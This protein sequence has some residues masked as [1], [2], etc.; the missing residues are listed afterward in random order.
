VRVTL[1][2]LALEDPCANKQSNAVLHDLLRV[3]KAKNRVAGQVHSAKMSRGP[4]RSFLEGKAWRTVKNV[5][6]PLGRIRIKREASVAENIFLI[7]KD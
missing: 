4:C 6:Y 5:G 7:L 1:L 3:H 2:V